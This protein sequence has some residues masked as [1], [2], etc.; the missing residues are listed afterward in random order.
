MVRWSQIFVPQPVFGFFPD[1]VTQI[2]IHMLLGFSSILAGYWYLKLNIKGFYL[3][4][5]V[6][7]VSMVSD[8]LSW[9][10]WDSV[11]EKM[12]LARRELQGLPVRDGEMEFM[13]SLFPE[14]MLLAT[15][16]AVV[17]MFLTRKRFI[18]S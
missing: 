12:V 5:T 14:G 17:A 2:L 7:I 15:G 6:A 10:L 11:V 1:D 3:A 18:N 9:N 13:Q 16:L 4:V 8:A